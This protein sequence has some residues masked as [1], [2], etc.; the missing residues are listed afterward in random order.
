MPDYDEPRLPPATPPT[1]DPDADPVSAR[2]LARD[3]GDS[4][5]NA[6]RGGRSASNEVGDPPQGFEEGG[7]RAE[8]NR[9]LSRRHA[10][11]GAGEGTLDAAR[12]E[13][14]LPPD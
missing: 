3:D 10:L 8:L 7:E 4:E 14:L 6:P 9:K 1:I 13:T 2:D 12:P 5:A 11:D